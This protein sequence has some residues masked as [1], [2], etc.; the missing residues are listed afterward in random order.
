VGD[1][2]EHTF[3]K[4]IELEPGILRVTL[5]LPTGPRHVHC[6]LLRGDD[7]W[8]LVDTGLGP[9]PLEGS[10]ARPAAPGGNSGTPAA[11][12]GT[13]WPEIA[14]G[15]DAPIVRIFIT[16]MHPDH[17]GGA[18]AAAAATGASVVQGRLDYAQCERV[19]GSG[20]WPRRIA[21]WFL[22]NGVPDPVAEELIES[23]HVFADFVR[24]A[25]NPLL[26]DPGDEVDGW[27]V[28]ATPG[29]ADGHLCLLRDGVLVAGDHVLTPITPAIGLYPESRQDPLGD[30]VD[31]LRLVEELAPR[32][33]YG[34]HGRTVP[35]PVVRAR[36]IV[37]HHE[38]RLDE[39][40]AALARAPQSGFELSHALFGTELPPIQR[41][42]AV[43]ETLSHLERLVRLGRAR[44]HED[45]RVVSYT[46]T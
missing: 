22:L 3:E 38:R 25:W 11:P 10:P 9:P 13:P 28:L 21:D 5:P 36:E 26:V 34:G 42:F 30:Y 16:H 41:R 2:S 27:R 19:W 14:A 6:Y 8:T 4:P 17:V 12:R 29:H 46:G 45:G 40:E 33:A 20:D 24:F 37:G 39:A 7:G 35:D 44:R 43:A 15:L 18:E 32:V 1:T 23:G 31:S